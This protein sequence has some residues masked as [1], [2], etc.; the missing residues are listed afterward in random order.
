MHVAICDVDR[1]A[2]GFTVAAQ[3]GPFVGAEYL[4]NQHGVV[5]DRALGRVK[6]VLSMSFLLRV[7]CRSIWAKKAIGRAS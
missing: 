1:G 2:C 5:M 6:R 7:L 4:E 3:G